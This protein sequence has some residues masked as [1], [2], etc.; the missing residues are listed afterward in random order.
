[1][2]QKATP[3][4]PAGMQEEMNILTSFE[5]V[6]ADLRGAVIH[7]CAA[8]FY[9]LYVNGQFVAFGPAIAAKG[10]AREDLVD[11]SSYHCDK[12]NTVEI[13]VMHYR[14]G[15]FVSPLQ[16]GFLLCE[17]ER[18][19]EVLLATGYDFNCR[20]NFAREQKVPRYSAQRHFEEIWDL[21]KTRKQVPFEA[22][23]SPEIIDRKAPY[24]HYEDILQ[25]TQLFDQIDLED[26]QQQRPSLLPLPRIPNMSY[27]LEARKIPCL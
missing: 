13:Q 9:R 20:L 16:P 15:S 11:L 2:F 23:A 1:M 24:P 27:Q 17:V 4:F 7:I 10:Y 25:Q 3:I 18:N 6:T 12:G 26:I 14:C 19:G 22:V 21:R 5:A 8:D